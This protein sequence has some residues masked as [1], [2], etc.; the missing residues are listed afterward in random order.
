MGRIFPGWRRA[1]FVVV[2]AVLWVASAPPV[3]AATAGPPTPP[4]LSATAAVLVDGQTGQ[5]LYSRNALQPLY[6]ASI[7]KI[8]T[9]YLAIRDGWTR[10]VRVSQAAQNQP[11]SSCYL[12]A[13]ESLPMPAVVDCMML[14]SGNDAAWAVAETV[15]GS[16]PAFVR[17]M[18]A[19]AQRWHAPGVH[20]TNPSGLPDP[21]HVVTALGM[22]VIA[23]HA[24]QNPIFRK[25]VALRTTTLPPDPKPR[26]YYNQ[27]RLLYDF[28]GAVGI[29]LGYTVEADETI[30]AAAEQHGV[31]LI[32]VLLHDTPQGLWPDAEHLLRWGF[33]QFVPDPVVGPR[34]ALPALTLGS[35]AVPVAAGQT[36]V[37]LAPRGQTVAVRW[38][39]DP[40]V[41]ATAPVRRGQTVGRLMV[42]VDGQP[43]GA[44]PLVA[45]QTDPARPPASWRWRDWP[46]ALALAGLGIGWWGRR[47][48]RRPRPWRIEAWP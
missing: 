21:N 11:G 31:L 35:R 34:T 28:P 10:T 19:T 29:K 24:M 22:A 12:R 16:V 8:M 7:T 37:Y 20:F 15:S 33:T 27:N 44:V 9:A 46:A 14:V 17:L 13:G 30:V 18:N 1:W 43:L 5:V 45:A 41:P 40:T 47:R 3:R 48:R 39:L 36:L 32:A 23:E 2:T 6:P 38:R 25:V 4:S 42:S 26:V